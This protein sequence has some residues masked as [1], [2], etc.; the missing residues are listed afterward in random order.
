M[1]NSCLRVNTSTNPTPLC[2][3][4]LYSSWFLVTLIARRWLSPILYLILSIKYCSCFFNPSPTTWWAN[5]VSTHKN[6][7]PWFCLLL[8]PASHSDVT[9][10]S[11]KRNTETTETICFNTNRRCQEDRVLHQIRQET[12]PDLPVPGPPPDGRN[13]P[14]EDDLGVTIRTATGYYSLQ[15]ATRYCNQLLLL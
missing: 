8:Q 11:S 7:F 12:L 1:Q 13:H 14:E 3:K 4:I 15:Y 10:P 5:Y 6:N 2:V 9:T